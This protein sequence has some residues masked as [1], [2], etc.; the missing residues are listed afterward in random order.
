MDIPSPPAAKAAGEI[1][2]TFG[3]GGIRRLSFS[4][5]ASDARVDAHGRILLASFSSFTGSPGF[6][7]QVY[8]A[9][10]LPDGNWDSSMNKLLPITLDYP[11]DARVFPMQANGFVALYSGSSV[12]GGTATVVA[13]KFDDAGNADPSYGAGGSA[14]L[15]V[16]GYV[17]P[18]GAPDGSVVVF[19]GTFPGP[20][21]AWRLD[22]RG[23]RDA[24]FEQNADDVLAGCGPVVSDHRSARQPDG[25]IVVLFQLESSYSGK[26][27]ISRLNAD[28]TADATFGDA[29]HAMLTGDAQLFRQLVAVLPLPGGGLAIVFNSQAL[30]DGALQA[31]NVF[32]L[33]PSG[34]ADASHGGLR[35]YD[36]L[37]FPI[38]AAAAAAVQAD[39]KV[40]LM[41]LPYDSQ[42]LRQ[43]DP[44]KPRLVRLDMQGNP[45]AAFGPGK[46]GFVTLDAGG[47]R[48]SPGRAIA[49][50]PGAVY[51]SGGA[52]PSGTSS[53]G[54]YLA[55]S[56]MKVYTG[57]P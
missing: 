35:S 44:T 36:A 8:F 4:N 12:I 37:A 26:W 18:V 52:A 27:C 13:Q 54:G 20:S 28:G 29:G 33:T 34:Q 43:P 17:D 9:R 2:A 24:A 11:Q 57:E 31:A 39:G 56:V 55:V 5:H 19:S 48:L 30:A 6:P 1:D 40:L 47:N 25:K 41:G 15:S 38:G 16:P 22:A 53:D 46:N 21:L 3:E 49:T 42:P 23:Q 50:G 51:P 32:W 7:A 45:D 10:V 14:T